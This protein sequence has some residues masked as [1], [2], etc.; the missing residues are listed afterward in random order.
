MTFKSQKN[1]Q[2]Q[3]YVIKPWLTTPRLR[4][5]NQTKLFDSAMILLNSVSLFD[6]ILAHLFRHL[7]RACRPMFRAAVF[8]NCPKH[9]DKPKS[10]QPNN[11]PGGGKDDAFD[12]AGG[13]FRQVND[14]SKLV[15]RV[16]KTRQYQRTRLKYPLSETFFQENLFWRTKF[17][18]KNCF[19]SVLIPN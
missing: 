17:Y 9:S 1:S 11:T 10:L 3:Q 5:F 14:V 15:Q 12:F 4:A 13:N 8:V 18:R 6:R 7:N 19:R 16:C 2:T